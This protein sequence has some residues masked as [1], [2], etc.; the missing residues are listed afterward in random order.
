MGKAVCFAPVRE[1]S[2]RVKHVNVKSS[3]SLFIIIMEQNLCRLYMV[4]QGRN[5]KK[6]IDEQISRP[7]QRTIQELEEDGIPTQLQP[8]SIQNHCS[9][10]TEY[11][12][13]LFKA[14]LHYQLYNKLGSHAVTYNGVKGT[15]FAVWAP[16]AVCVSLIGSF[17]GWNREPHKMQVRWDGSGIWELFVPGL[18]KGMYYKYFIEARNGW[19][20]E[21]GDPYA[22][23]WETPP[24][25]ASVIWDPE[26][27]WTDSQWMKERTVNPVMSR[28]LSVYEVHLGSWRKTEDNRFLT[29]RELATELPAYCVEMG[30]TYAE[31]MPVMEHPFFGS[32]GYQITGYFAPTS[33]FGTPEDF[34][35]LVNELHR[36]GIGVILDW[37]PSHFPGDAHGLY[38]FDGTHLYEH[39]DPR[40][41][42][43]PDWN[44]YIFNYGRNEVRAFLISNTLYWFDKYHID[45]LRVDAVA[46]MIYLDY[47][48]KEGE[49]EPNE[50]GGRENLDVLF[51]LR[52]FNHAVHQFHPDVFT[53]AEESTAFPGVT[54]P[55]QEGGLGFDMK[56]MMGWMHDT[57][58]YFSRDPMY[59]SHHHGQLSFSIMYAFSEKF[60]LPLSHDEVVY[61]K[62]SLINKMPGDNWQ[63]FAGLRLL[64]SYMYGHPG[65]KMIFQG[66]EFAQRGEWRHDFS[67][68]WHEAVSEPHR[69]I[70]QL[71][72]DLNRLYRLQPALYEYNFSGQGFEW[73]DFN[74][75]GNSVLCWVRKGVQQEEFLLFLASFTPLCRNN[76]R[77]GVPLMGFYEEIFNS[78]DM[79]YGGSGC[80]N[81]GRLETS[82]ILRH[83]RTHSLSV[84]LPPLGL[85]VLKYMEG[86]LL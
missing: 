35:F 26:F 71:V 53:I 62:G 37:V 56:W 70:Q 33:R 39:P 10:F 13:H 9:L 45:G 23:H 85:T 20:G 14:G 22:F 83:G 77:I 75:A 72:A 73:L 18:A 81:E 44:S 54:R 30:F 28:A 21:K 6:I 11:D 49:W 69:G 74:D 38:Q 1:G 52:E 65:A 24:A 59:R 42:F 27:R 41:G 36:A 2:E 60:L 84:T 50:H 5:K 34:M 8:E 51:F 19:T 32:W 68:D 7:A 25:T 61:G 82:P 4:N 79:K 47:S 48:R 80:I 64:F 40:K 66:G 46:S 76:Y 86:Y 57:L 67:L 12:I 58:Q 55:L 43:H 31:L 63:Q 3:L 17:N 29:Y 78:D 16:N 15:Y